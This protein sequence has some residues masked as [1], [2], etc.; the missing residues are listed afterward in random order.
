MLIFIRNAVVGAVFAISSITATPSSAQDGKSPPSEIYNIY[1]S[2]RQNT[3]KEVEITNAALGALRRC[4]IKAISDFTYAYSGMAPDLMIALTGP[5]LSV[6]VANAELQ[7]AKRCGIN[8][9]IKRATL[10]GGE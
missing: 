8:G 5:H 10:V 9:Y 3:G 4:A 2:A 1:A 7:K 6:S